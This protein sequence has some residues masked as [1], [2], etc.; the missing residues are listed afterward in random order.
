MRIFL[1][2][3]RSVRSVK[4]IILAFGWRWTAGWSRI[5]EKLRLGNGIGDNGSR[6]RHEVLSA[7]QLRGSIDEVGLIGALTEPAITENCSPSSVPE[8]LVIR[9][10]AGDRA[11][12]IKN[13]SL[14]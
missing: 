8:S 5:R 1:H 9:F 3:H 6:F 14:L 7:R 4:K 11:W 12:T 10:H 2:A 13:P